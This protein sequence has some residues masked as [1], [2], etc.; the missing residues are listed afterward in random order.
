MNKISHTTNY[1]VATSSQYYYQQ[2][3]YQHS[4]THN[5]MTYMLCVCVC[6]YSI[7]TSLVDICDHLPN[8]APHPIIISSLSTHHATEAFCESSITSTST[9]TSNIVHH[10]NNYIVFYQRGST[11]SLSIFLNNMLLDQYL[12]TQAAATRTSSSLIKRF[13][14]ILCLYLSVCVC[15][16]Y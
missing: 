5:I 1:L 2:Y 12:S 14:K 11:S 6:V 4:S 10:H 13:H 16:I 15:I 9:S 8:T 7:T 3:Y